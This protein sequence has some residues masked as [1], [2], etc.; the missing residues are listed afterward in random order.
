MS[1]AAAADRL[2]E[3]SQDH[4]P[5]TPP[6]R[7]RCFS[8]VSPT[9]ASFLGYDAE[10]T[11]P[12]ECLDP[13]ITESQN[14]LVVLIDGLRYD[15]W[16]E[17]TAL[18]FSCAREHGTTT[19]LSAVFPTETAAAIV[20][21]HTGRQPIEHGSLGWEQYLPPQDVVVEPLRGATVD[22]T[23]ISQLDDDPVEL[24]DGPTI[25]RELAEM[26]VRSTVIQPKH[27]LVHDGAAQLYE[28]A[29]Q[30]PY[31]TPADGALAAMD[32]LAEPG[33]SFVSLYLPEVDTISHNEGT[34]SPD[35]E[36]TLQMID[37]C[38]RY[39]IDRLAPEIAAETAV[40]F[41]SDHGH[42]DIPGSVGTVLTDDERISERLR[43]RPN[44]TPMPPTG[45]LRN[46][47]LHLKDRSIEPVRQALD[48]LAV[49]TWTQTEAIDAEL[50][51]T[52]DCSET[53]RERCGDLI[54]VPRDAPIW[55]TDTKFDMIGQ[56]G[57]LDPAE[58]LVPFT[59]VP[60]REL[61]S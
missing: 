55:H 57:G 39:A 58:L 60:M 31:T 51:G 6:Y 46:V 40:G 27:T 24:F 48:S 41:V 29:T 30:V 23:P 12:A 47:H 26:D 16:L 20:S 56:H 49:H 43:R 7:D 25:H 54:I 8:N 18:L 36:A 3:V 4:D 11:L 15:R 14:V 28:G 38:L 21:Y 37:G 10:H 59:T 52:H 13:A 45:S 1:T 9:L 35:Y 19:P 34:E 5:H 32:A 50:F 44:G 42:I 33:P 2:F 17:T 53:F 61:Y 22:G